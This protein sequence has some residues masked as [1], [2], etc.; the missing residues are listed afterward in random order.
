MIAMGKMVRMMGGLMVGAGLLSACSSAPSPDNAPD[1]FWMP[2]QASDTS[3]TSSC[4]P[5]GLP[6]LAASDHVLPERWM[7]ASQKLAA[8]DRVRIRVVGDEDRLSGL[9]RLD[10]QGRISLPGLPP[11]DSAGLSLEETETRLG[12]RLVSEGLIQ[13]LGR[14][15]EVSLVE[16]AVLPIPVS[17]AVFSPGTV[18]VGAR[19]AEERLVAGEGILSGDANP[20][21]S[22][23][24]AIRNAGGLRP[25]A[26]PAHVRVLRGEQWTELDLSGLLE[27]RR[28]IDLQVSPGD[29]IQVPSTG[30]FN[31]QL[32]RPGPLTPPGVRVFMSNLSR[33]AASNASSAIGKEA[34]SLPYGTRLLQGLVSA[35]CV[36]GSAMSAHRQALLIS[37]NP[38]SQ[39]S[40]VIKRDVEAML[41]S[42]GRDRINP[43]LMPGDAIACYDSRMMNV[44]DA[45][46]MFG[47]ALGS[48]STAIL[49][50]DLAQ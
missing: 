35:N 32:V 4:V 28:F 40:V 12:E 9:Y 15:V 19:S 38:I 41:T 8:G 43:F 42:A 30:C 47:N 5:T 17:G 50:E 46:A 1:A 37:T 44:R 29:R 6:P 24:A 2:H 23:S 10:D 26:D 34:T 49:L 25:D 36:G 33:P 39:K 16:R 7:K 48:V 27:G 14:V 22:V 13:P 21:R 20:G 3:R 31:E 45:I 11:L 18:E